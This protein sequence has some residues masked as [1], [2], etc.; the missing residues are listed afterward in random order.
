MYSVFPLRD[1]WGLPKGE[2][3][4][5]HLRRNTQCFSIQRFPITPITYILELHLYLVI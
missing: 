5:V 2:E 4:I 3:D 1:Y